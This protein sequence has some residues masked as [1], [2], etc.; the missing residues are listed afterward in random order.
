MRVSGIA[1]SI[2]IYIKILL[3]KI[4]EEKSMKTN[5]NNSNTTS[6]E[7]DNCVNCDKDL[8]HFL[9][10]SGEKGHIDVAN[11]INHMKEFDIG[12]IGTCAICGKI[13]AYGGHNPRPFLKDENAR[14]CSLCHDEGVIP[15]RIQSVHSANKGAKKKSAENLGPQAI[16]KYVLDAGR[17][18]LIS[19]PINRG[20]SVSKYDIISAEYNE[21]FITFKQSN[22]GDD[23]MID[24]K[25][26]DSSYLGATHRN[27]IFRDFNHRNEYNRF[28]LCADYDEAEEFDFMADN[29]RPLKPHEIRACLMRAAE[30]ESYIN[31]WKFNI[32]PDSEIR[33]YV[34]F[35]TGKVLNKNNYS[36]L[37]EILIGNRDESNPIIYA[38]GIFIPLKASKDSISLI[39]DKLYMDPIIKGLIWNLAPADQR[40]KLCFDYYTEYESHYKATDSEI[41]RHENKL[42]EIV[43]D[44]TY[45]I[46][47][48]LTPMETQ[49][50]HNFKTKGDRDSYYFDYMWDH[51][52]LDWSDCTGRYLKKVKNET[53]AIGMKAKVQYFHGTQYNYD[54]LFVKIKLEGDDDYIY[55]PN[56]RTYSQLVIGR[57]YGY[58]QTTDNNIAFFRN[59]FNYIPKKAEE[60]YAIGIIHEHGFAI[61]TTFKNG[62]FSG[63]FIID[64]PCAVEAAKKSITE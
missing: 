44:D 46:K 35:R 1:G 9:L 17:V 45:F 31:Y 6:F 39:K 59:G 61:R 4:M 43:F 8:S 2:I 49:F 26:I 28:R 7:A 21:P 20:D 56:L 13:Y 63:E 40:S 54:E 60:I 30:L 58:E 14:C 22:G 18:K 29:D 47:P 11:F 10:H 38:N 32:S 57:A 34:R 27:D 19:H 41:N 12:P 36:H 37:F 50:G 53:T 16:V 55:L 51:A 24:A 15:T 33:T 42:K 48:V 3:I 62:A 23:I 25:T 5:E 64:D 52:L